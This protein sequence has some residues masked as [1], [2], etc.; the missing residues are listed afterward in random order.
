MSI[1]LLTIIT[2]KYELYLRAL[3]MN[4]VSKSIE[5]QFSNHIYVQLYLKTTLLTYV[6]F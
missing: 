6:Q 4:L 5:K 3:S 1:Q 2:Y